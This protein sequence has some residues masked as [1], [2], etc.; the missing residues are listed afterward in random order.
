VMYRPYNQLT[1]GRYEYMELYNNGSTAVDLSGAYLTDSS[2]YAAVCQHLQPHD[3][4]G[5]F[6]I[7]GGTVVQPGAFL[8]F[9]HASVT[10][11][12]DGP[13]NINYTEM[14]DFG[15]LVLN[16]N[17]DQVTVLRCSGITPVI[18]DSL[19]YGALGIGEASPNVSIERIDPNGPTQSA[20]NWG[21]TLV[22]PGTNNPFGYSPGG[23]PGAVNSL[24]S[25]TC[26][27][28]ISGYELSS[29]FESALASANANDGDGY[30][31]AVDAYS[32]PCTTGVAAT[33]DDAVTAVFGLQD[34]S[35]W[36]WADGGVQSVSVM[37]GELAPYYDSLVAPLA[38]EL[39]ASGETP[40]IHEYYATYYVAPGA[41]AWRHGYIVLFPTSHKIAVLQ[42][43]VQE[44]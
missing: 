35:Y 38:A 6:L 28:N 7:P 15:N 23:T 11:V 4:E 29:S 41:M 19:D 43:E 8:T 40:L 25:A 20:S 33:L 22:P 31:L 14:Q 30:S 16:D 34:F 5:I 13:G 27:V 18:I 39:G 9:W 10:G 42:K 32:F 36:P 12:T 44:T 1:F 3:H 17:G 2:D 24:T 26:D 21:F 37:T